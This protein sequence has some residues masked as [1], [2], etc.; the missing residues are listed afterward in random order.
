MNRLSL[1]Q[2]FYQQRK[3]IT[4]A[5]ILNQNDSIAKQVGWK[6]YQSQLANF[7]RA[8]NINL[9]WT[10]VNHILDVGCG[11]GKLIEYLRNNKNYQGKY[12][13]IDL[14]ANFVEGAKKLYGD[15]PR[16]NFL[17]GDFLT[18]GLENEFAY[19][20]VFCLGALSVN[21]DQ[22]DICGQKSQEYAQNLITLMSQMAKLAIILYFPSEDDLPIKQKE[23]FPDMAFYKSIE[24]EN[25]LR[26]VTGKRLKSLEIQSDNFK[27]IVRVLLQS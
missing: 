16:N 10:E 13:G 14:I 1:T 7:E 26:D 19:D 15:D 2:N 24:I 17:V 22:P 4:E 3:K 25:M 11:Y 9:D 23:S 6:S 21:Y 8:V 18:Q 5:L 12:T 27:T 20:I